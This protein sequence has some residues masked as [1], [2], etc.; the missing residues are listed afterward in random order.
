MPADSSACCHVLSRDALPACLPACLWQLGVVGP[1]WQMPIRS[2]A[3]A[4][5]RKGLA[6]LGRHLQ[7]PTSASLQTTILANWRRGCPL[8]ACPPAILEEGQSE[9]LISIS[10]S[11]AI[12]C[13]A[14][15]SMRWIRIYI[16]GGAAGFSPPLGMPTPCT[17][18]GRGR[19]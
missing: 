8:P 9:Q 3:W 19:K 11:T 13:T 2:R 16:I 7:R 4:R 14:I 15:T 18:R 1:N 10:I 6:R 17:G 12:L 5:M